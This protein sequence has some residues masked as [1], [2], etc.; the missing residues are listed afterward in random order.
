VTARRRSALLTGIA[1]ACGA[2]AGGPEIGPDTFG[3]PR[4]T[5]SH[6]RYTIEV[7]GSNLLAR[8]C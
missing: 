8:L 3:P 1:L 2:L 4:R 5:Y 7:R 6:Q